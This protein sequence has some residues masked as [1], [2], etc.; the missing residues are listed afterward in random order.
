ML[1]LVKT[2]LDQRFRN[3]LNVGIINANKPINVMVASDQME[4][5]IGR[6]GAN[7]KMAERLLQVDEINIKQLR[8]K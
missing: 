3:V 8:E 2:K 7:V 6:R 4:L 1:G 5:A